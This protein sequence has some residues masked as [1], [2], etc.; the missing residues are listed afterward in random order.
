MWIT[1]LSSGEYWV[2]NCGSNVE[3]TASKFL[4]CFVCGKSNF[5]V[6]LLFNNEQTTPESIVE[7]T[8]S[9]Y[10]SHCIYTGCAR[11]VQVKFYVRC[12]F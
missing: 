5:R 3:H 7:V 11:V 1:F 10:F 2:R 9:V 6:C 12:Q 8:M 4:T